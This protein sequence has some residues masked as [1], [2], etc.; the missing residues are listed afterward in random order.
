MTEVNER[1]LREKNI[2]IY[3]LDKSSSNLKDV[4]RKHDMSLFKQITDKCG[5]QMGGDINKIIRLCKPEQGKSRP[6]QIVMEEVEKKAGFL[7][8]FQQNKR[9]L[10]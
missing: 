5:V 2:I 1:K 9:C 3:R 10:R 8:K 6:L 7:C 4:K